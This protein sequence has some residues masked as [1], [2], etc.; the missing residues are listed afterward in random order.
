MYT[1]VEC[2]YVGEVRRFLRLNNLV[3]TSKTQVEN[4]KELC[5]ARLC[6]AIG[7]DFK[8]DYNCEYFRLFANVVGEAVCRVLNINL[9]VGCPEVRFIRYNHINLVDRACEILKSCEIEEAFLD[10][11]NFIED[12]KKFVPKF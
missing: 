1:V 11:Y 7:I 12:S 4:I 5:V 9:V 3:L 8:Y 10:L 6:N 2:E